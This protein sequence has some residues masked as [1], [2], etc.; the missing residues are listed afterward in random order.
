MKE[1]IKI[2]CLGLITISIVIF[3]ITYSFKVLIDYGCSSPKKFLINE[4][5]E[6]DIGSFFQDHFWV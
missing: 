4:E 2:I 5:A 1:K 3:S 6:S